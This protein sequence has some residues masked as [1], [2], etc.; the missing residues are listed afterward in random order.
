[1]LGDLSELLRRSLTHGGMSDEG[2]PVANP[3]V[4]LR[5]E[6]EFSERYLHIERVRFGPE[7]LS[8]R[9]SVAPETLEARVPGFLLQPLV[10]NAVRHG[11]TQ[12]ESTGGEV[13]LRAW[14]E[15]AQLHLEVRD[16]GPGLLPPTTGLR[17][18]PLTRRG[19]SRDGH[20]VG[21][22]N[23]RERLRRIYRAGEHAFT[24]ENAADG[25]GA[26]VHLVLPFQTTTA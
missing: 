23:V 26:R 14:K 24:C 19:R 5:E 10:E 20:G 9:R 22:S 17:S 13:E 1:M 7:R 16:N 4:S 6:L 25:S 21:L 15:G 11:V 12:R 8:V 2:K 3:L 18:V